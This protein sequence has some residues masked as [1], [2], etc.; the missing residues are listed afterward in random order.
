VVITF[1]DFLCDYEKKRPVF[2]Q[3]APSNML[4]KLIVFL[5]L[6]TGPISHRDSTIFVEISQQKR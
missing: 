6:A 3:D 2:R 4:F 5:I 1:G